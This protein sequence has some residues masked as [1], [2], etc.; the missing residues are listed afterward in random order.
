MHK[1]TEWFSQSQCD[2]YMLYTCI[3]A[4]KE[5][6]NFESLLLPGHINLYWDK[7]SR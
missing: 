7:E 5:K 3:R 2:A 4:W 1:I 6:S